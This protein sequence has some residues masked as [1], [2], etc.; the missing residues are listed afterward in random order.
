MSIQIVTDIINAASY[1]A[2]HVCGSEGLYQCI[3]YDTAKRN[4]EVESIE[5]EVSVILP[6]GKTGYLD[7][8]IE[9]NGISVAIELKA[10]ANSYRNSLD[11]AKEV[12]RRFG[13]EKSGGLLKDF[14]KLSAFLK[15]GVKSS[16]H[17][18]SVCL[19]TA[20]I[21]KGFTPHD[22]DRYSTLANR[23]SI[24][25]VYGTPG[26][27]PT[28]LW[29]T[30]DTQYELALGVED[31][32]GV[33][34]SN[35]FDIDNLDWA[36][37]FAF[38]GMLEPKD[39][40]FAQG[41]LYHYIRNMGLSERQCASEVYFF[42]AR[43]PDSRASYWVPDL[44]VFDTSFNGKFNLGVNN[45]EKLRNDY[46]KLCSL[47]TI[48]EIKGSKLFERLSTNQKIKMIRQDLEKLNSHLRPV[49]EAQILKGEISRKRPVNY[50]MVIASS[51]VGLKPF[52]SEA[53][54]EYGESIQ[55]YWSGFY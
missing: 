28:N 30:S 35:A 50:A 25:F 11:K 8:V 49:I 22:V 5:R 29:V 21:K 15:G 17:A 54:K 47:N 51:D 37:Y 19:E 33:E 31:G 9:A 2:R 34:V 10:G 36:T 38:V 4:P 18:I 44:A 52:I 32:N 1:Q 40:T 39:E 23:K 24:D 6:D 14:E 13:A 7:F 42:F 16:R 46:E 41:I 48:I 43:K 26:S 55:I 53:M 45:Q 20:Y 12:D 27:S 3:I